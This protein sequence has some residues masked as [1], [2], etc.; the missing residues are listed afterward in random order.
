MKRLLNKWQKRL[1]L[2]DWRIT[3]E[4]VPRPKLEAGCDA[5]VWWDSDDQAAT[6]WICDEFTESPDSHLVHELIHIVLD[7]DGECPEYSVHHERK[8]NKITRALL[9]Q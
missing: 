9:K 3:V 7:G 8:I 4:L 6:I 2:Q 5:N 1:G